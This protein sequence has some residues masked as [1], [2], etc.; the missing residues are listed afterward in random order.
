M[1]ERH[2][3]LIEQL[4]YDKD[5]FRKEILKSFWWLKSYEI[6]QLYVWLKK[7]FGRTHG[8]VIRD[9]FEFIAA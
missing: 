8:D 2:K 9:V 4:S 1:L 7:N 3:L 5:L 6:I